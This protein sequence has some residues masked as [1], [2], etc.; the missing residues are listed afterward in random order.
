MDLSKKFLYINTASDPALF[1]DEA[2]TYPA[3]GLKAIYEED[4]TNVVLALQNNVAV[5][6]DIFTV[7]VTSG[8]ARTFMKDLVN[9]INYGSEAFLVVGDNYTHESLSGAVVFTTDITLD[10]EAA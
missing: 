9:A 1:V 7:T 3:S 10:N 6:C 8:E 2:R 4:A 5:D